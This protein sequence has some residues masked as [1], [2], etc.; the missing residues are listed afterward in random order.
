MTMSQDDDEKRSHSRLWWLA[1]VL[2]PVVYVLS[3][4][5]AV[6]YGGHLPLVEAFYGP[7]VWLCNHSTLAENFLHWWVLE[8]WSA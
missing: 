4:G 5:P 8:V 7:V 2:V 3:V 1:L 6:V